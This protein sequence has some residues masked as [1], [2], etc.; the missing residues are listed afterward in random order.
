MGIAYIHICT[1]IMIDTV[2]MFVNSYRVIVHCKGTVI[3]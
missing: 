1:I 2:R 3:V